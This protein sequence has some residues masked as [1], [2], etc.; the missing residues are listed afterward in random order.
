[1]AE[2]ELELRKLAPG[3]LLLVNKERSSPFVS[4]CLES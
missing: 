2:L 1:M 4:Y 3:P